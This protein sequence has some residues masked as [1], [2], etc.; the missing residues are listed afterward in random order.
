M[1]SSDN[2]FL[3]K[4][5]V[6]LVCLTTLMLT[7]GCNNGTNVKW[8]YQADVV[9]IGAGGAGLPAGLKAMEDGASVLFVET[10]WDVG[11]HAAVSEGQL[12]SGGSTVSQKEWGIE[13]SADL[14]YYDHTRGGAA[15]SRFNDFIQVRSVA[16][17][18]AKAYDFIL[19]NGVKILEI[20]PMVR[21]YYRDGGSDP[22]SVGR[23]TYSDSGEW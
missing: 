6:L 9:I 5:A 8:D 17:S 7:V 23:M 22:D 11:G 15:D 14:Y 10:N 1:K 12:H 2:R 20:E 18:M 4:I 21:N 3:S 13:D 19:K 16:N